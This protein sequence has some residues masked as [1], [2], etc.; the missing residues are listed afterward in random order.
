[1]EEKYDLLENEFSNLCDVAGNKNLNIILIADRFLA[2]TAEKITADDLNRIIDNAR[3]VAVAMQ[4]FKKA[5]VA[6]RNSKEA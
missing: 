5:F 2:P 6:Y 4:A 3:Q 1:M